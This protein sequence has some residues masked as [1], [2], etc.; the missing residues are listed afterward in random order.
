MSSL[1][2]EEGG[3]SSADTFR[4]R[5]GVNVSGRMDNPLDKSKFAFLAKL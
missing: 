2:R 1:Q 5:G 4:T 3:L